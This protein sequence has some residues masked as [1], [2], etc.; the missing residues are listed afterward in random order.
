M[1]DN[2]PV[3]F[4]GVRQNAV[5]LA[6]KFLGE[7]LHAGCVAV[8]ATAGN[9]HDTLFLAGLV[10]E[11]GKVYAFDVQRA[12]LDN[13]YRRLREAGLAGRVVLIN[14]GHE[15]MDRYLPGPV[16]GFMFNL[17]YLPGGDHS[18]LTRPETTLQALE[19]A[20]GMLKPGGRISVV[21]YTGHR[22]AGEESRAVEEMA[23]SLDPG[24][25]GVLKVVFAN[26]SALAPFLIL[27]EKVGREDENL[28]PEENTGNNKRAGDR[29]PGGTG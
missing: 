25:Y 10:G 13:T 2:L 15:R 27:V 5:L 26:R 21:V 22:G 20:A 9:G 4:A 8:D 1:Y 17:G 6:Q 19:L 23:S 16:D 3:R 29:Y 7:I 28:A 18:R 11:S 12:A 14:D 24:T